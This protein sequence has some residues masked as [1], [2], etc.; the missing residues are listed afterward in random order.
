MPITFIVVCW[1]LNGMAPS[2]FH[3]SIARLAVLAKEE[4]AGHAGIVTDPAQITL[5][6]AL[7]STIQ[8]ATC[9][10][11]LACDGA[12][13]WLYSAARPLPRGRAPRGRNNASKSGALRC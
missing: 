6:T 2:R 5:S 9:R 4:A 10:L 11:E 1:P 8:C 12:N 13:S 3:P 7:G